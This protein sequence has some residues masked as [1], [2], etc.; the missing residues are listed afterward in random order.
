MFGG[1]VKPSATGHGRA[2][3]SNDVDVGRFDPQAKTV[4]WTR[5][6]GRAINQ[7]VIKALRLNPATVA[8]APAAARRCTT[9]LYMPLV[10]L[11]S[12]TCLPPSSS[13]PTY[14]PKPGQE[15]GG[16]GCRRGRRSGRLRRRATQEGR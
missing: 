4:A 5:M 10:R 14:Y 3:L 6:Y 2:E 9:L 13:C 15:C 7:T 16:A 11:T 8:A 1:W 12:P